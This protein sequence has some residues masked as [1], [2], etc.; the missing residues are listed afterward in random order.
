MGRT[1]V[2]GGYALS[3]VHGERSV[4]QRSVVKVVEV[5]IAA[6]AIKLLSDV[7]GGVHL[8][9]ILEGCNGKGLDV[10]HREVEI[11]P[12][13]PVVGVAVV[14]HLVG[15][16]VVVTGV[17]HHHDESAVQGA[18][19][20]L[21]IELTRGVFAGCGHSLA[22]LVAEGVGEL[23]DG[24]AKGNDQH[25]V[26]LAEHLGLALLDILL[27]L[28]VSQHLAQFEPLLTELGLDDAGHLGGVIGRVGLRLH[29]SRHQSVLLCE[30]GYT[31][32]GTTVVE[33]I[34]EEE[35][36]ARVVNRFATR[37]DDSL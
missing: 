9:T 37:V 25:M 14:L 22:L 1:T 21:L 6:L 23:L 35:L 12:V 10:L 36:N 19:D 7:I 31:A 3:L 2:E 26:Y 33:R 29:L 5:G 18:T 8:A 16:V 11:L 13:V 30:V 27:F 15:L 34:V 24:L 4:E 28:S 20:G 17:V 32:E